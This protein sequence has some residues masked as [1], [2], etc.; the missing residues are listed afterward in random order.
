M[1]ERRANLEHNGIE[2][3]ALR[4]L[5]DSVHFRLHSLPRVPR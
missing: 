1:A 5:V 3:Q 2:S 4:Y